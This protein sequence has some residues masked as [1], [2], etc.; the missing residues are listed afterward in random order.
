MKPSEME[1]SNLTAIS[2][3]DGRYRNFV[4]DL[5]PYLSEYGLIYYRTLVEV[6]CLFHH[7]FVFLLY[8]VFIIFV[9]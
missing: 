4:K 3:L 1:L 2:P 5:A 6:Q 9:P 7:P 8:V